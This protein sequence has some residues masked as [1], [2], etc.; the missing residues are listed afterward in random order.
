MEMIREMVNGE[1]YI[2]ASLSDQIVRSP[3][4]C[5]G[6]PTFKYT[7]IEV[8][9]LST[10]LRMAKHG[11]YRIRLCGQNKSGGSATG[12]RVSQTSVV[13]QLAGSSSLNP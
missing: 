2:Y 4:I 12:C 11:E 5:G 6:R 1:L 8:A 9:E 10:G 13:G 3:D 7:R